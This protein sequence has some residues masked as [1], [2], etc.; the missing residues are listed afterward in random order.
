MTGTLAIQWSRFNANLE[1][2]GALAQRLG[3]ADFPEFVAAAEFA[4]AKAEEHYR[5]FLSGREVTPNGR[6]VKHPT[7]ATARGVRREESGLLTWRIFNPSPVAKALEEGSPE[8]D[9]KA[10]LPN[11]K[12]VRR[13]KDGQLYLIIPFRHGTPGTRGMAA[14]PQSLYDRVVKFKWSRS[15]G[16]PMNRTSATGWTVPRF[17]YRWNDS[18]DKAWMEKQGFDAGDIKKFAGMYRMKG[19]DGRSSGYLTFRVMSE[20]SKG[21]IRP[22]MPGFFPLRQAIDLALAENMAALERAFEADVATTLG[23]VIAGG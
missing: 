8:R 3:P 2:L 9:M 18:V 13:G 12:R 22:A 19:H 10:M 5:G 15:L 20:K 21:W 1:D 4:S 6:A 23:L 7:G 14:M 11:A 16:A 17:S